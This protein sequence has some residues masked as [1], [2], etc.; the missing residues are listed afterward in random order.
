[1]RPYAIDFATVPPVGTWIDY[2]GE[3]AE[4]V[5]VKPYTRKTDGAPSFLLRWRVGTRHGT[6]GLRANSVMW[7]RDGGTDA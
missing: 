3:L 4:L 7:D 2:R 6:S 1:M 5:E